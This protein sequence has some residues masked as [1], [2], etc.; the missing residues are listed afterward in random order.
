[1]AHQ[2]TMVREHFEVILDI[3]DEMEADNLFVASGQPYSEAPSRPVL[4]KVSNAPAVLSDISDE[5]AVEEF[6]A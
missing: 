4:P 3:T 1:M 6:Q 5:V 2:V